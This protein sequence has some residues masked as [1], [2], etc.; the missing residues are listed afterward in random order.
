MSIVV[1][2]LITVGSLCLLTANEWVYLKFFGE[3]GEDQGKITWNIISERTG[4]VKN[5]IWNIFTRKQ[6]LQDRIGLSEGCYFMGNRRIDEIYVDSSG[7]R[8][9]LYINVQRERVFLT[10]LKGYVSIE[11]HTVYAN[12]TI[13]LEIMEYSK[14]R[15]ADIELQFSKRRALC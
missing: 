11:N 8:I 1:F 14:I 5:S 12:D 10:V 15:I 2:Q 13:R 7:P 6:L 9:K 4:T 3:T